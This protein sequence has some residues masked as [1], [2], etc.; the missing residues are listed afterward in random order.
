MLY[1]ATG[2]FSA[3]LLINLVLIFG[4]I[5]RLRGHTQ[6]LAELGATRSTDV[7]AAG[8]R[9]E[10]FAT[11]DIAGEPVSRDLL[12]AETVVAFFSLNCGFCDELLPKFVEYAASSTG[13]SAEFFG[14]ISGD[15]AEDSGFVKELAPVARV[16]IEEFDGP[17]TKAFGVTA[18]PMIFVMGAE[19]VVAS[20]GIGVGALQQRRVPAISAG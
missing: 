18:F 16:V 13:G 6:L 14:V 1:A 7:V 11:V 12:S 15:G 2:F 5:R 4:V 20:S 17:I 8:S 19:G 3:L 10:D 9:V